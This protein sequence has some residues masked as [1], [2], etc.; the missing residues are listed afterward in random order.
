MQLVDTFKQPI[1]ICEV[2]NVIILSPIDSYDSAEAFLTLGLLSSKVWTFLF[3]LQ[4]VRLY[5]NTK[6]WRYAEYSIEIS[7]IFIMIIWKQT[8][9][10]QEREQ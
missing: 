3:L 8:I 4:I 7:L 6:Y 10:P 9:Y 2:T 1:R 5:Y